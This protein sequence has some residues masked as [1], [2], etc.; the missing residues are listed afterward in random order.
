MN[1]LLSFLE[2]HLGSGK[3]D[4]KGNYTFHCPFCQHH[5]PKL[6]INI[7]PDN[8]N[9]Q[10]WNCWVCGTSNNSRGSKL[11]FL[12]K[13]MDVSHAVLSELRNILNEDLEGIEI[14]IEPD[15]VTLPEYFIPLYNIDQTK[16]YHQIP[17][18]YLYGRNITMNDIVKYRMGY[19]NGGEFQNY[20]IIPSFDSTGK[21]NY[22]YGR[23]YMND[24]FKH[25]FPPLSKNF[26]GFELFI[27]FNM[28][29]ILVEGAFDAITVKRNAIPLFGKSISESLMKK[30]LNNSCKE[31]IISL[32]SDAIENALNIGMNLIS[33]GKK[34]YLITFNKNDDP[35]S[36]GYENF[37]NHYYKNK[38]ELTQETYIKF[39]LKLSM[40]VGL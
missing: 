9:F 35:N 32:D 30:I 10:R 33:Y 15:C 5:K 26:I 12:F 11:Y 40:G 21:L 13:K 4:R 28:P 37:W 16:M 36:V 17:L 27:N 2:L 8:S 23:N 19:C 7:N 3:S 31:I 25:K 22:F 29:I 24:P 14:P 34:V 18:R 6:T 1:D 20:I 38:I 39:N